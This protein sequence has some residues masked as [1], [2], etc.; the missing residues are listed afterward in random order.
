MTAAH[1]EIE[2][3]F[4][5]PAVAR[6][7][8]AAELA[9]QG[10]VRRSA[11]TAAYFDTPDLRLARAGLA[12]RM[13]CE[14]GVWVQALKMAGSGALERFEHEV[15]RPDDQ[16]DALAHAGTRPGRRLAKL[17]ARHAAGERF[18]TEVQ[19]ITCRVDTDGAVVEI[20]LDEGRVVAGTASQPIGE[21]EFE[22]VS[23]SPLAMLALVARWRDRFGLVYDPHNKAERGHHLAAGA[24]YPLLR[25]ARPAQ[26]DAGMSPIGAFGAV[27]D[28]CLAQIS[29]NAFGLVD[30]DSGQRAA[31]V[32][33]MR[34][35]IRRL[36][37]ALRA[38]RG[39]VPAPPA[40][41]VEGLRTL[42]AALG[43]A[44]DR[45]VLAAGL[46]G[47]RRGAGPR[48]ADAQRRHAAAAAGGHRV[49]RRLR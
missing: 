46:R 29:R 16:P 5:V 26:V 23:G 41:W 32:H 14:D 20:A 2:L 21:V 44:R 36:R 39:W 47:R 6:E 45:D 1:A 40:G 3:K 22:L 9:A 28:E 34:V 10:A 49:A 48:R 42:F 4:L 38:F 8:L 19:R 11:L 43:L 37:S 15:V 24:P 12:W 31:H 35:G 30:G 13:R 27:V 18:R 7:A 25:H 17:L 33:Q